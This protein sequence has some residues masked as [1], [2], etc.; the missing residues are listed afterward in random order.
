MTLINNDAFARKAKTIAL[1]YKTVYILGCFGAPMNDEN[2]K[3]Y[4]KNYWYNGLSARKKKI[5][6]ASSDTFG[7]DC[8]CLIKGILWGWTGNTSMNYGGAKYASNNVP[9]VNANQIMKY[10]TEVSSDFSKIEIG[11]LVH[12]SRHVGIYI[13]DGLVVECTPNWKDGVQITAVANIGLKE[14][15]N[16]RKW[17]KHG[18]LKYVRYREN[19][20]L[21]KDNQEI[22]HEVIDGKW[23]NYPERKYRLTE[24]GYNYAEIQKIV[25]QLLMHDE[26]QYYDIPDYNG[27]SI[28]DALKA[29]NVDSTFTNRKKIAERNGFLNYSGTA[30][31]NMKLLNLLKI[32]KL[33]K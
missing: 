5:L 25:N 29:I 3:R 27:G 14:G 31:E 8:V 13:G 18:K 28:V 20:V 7:F 6:N 2:K 15:Y 30:Q 12:I 33:L 19:N 24:A 9:D 17:S 23:G 16:S 1:N 22:A 26:N 4:V 32:G 10:C 21:K 11:E